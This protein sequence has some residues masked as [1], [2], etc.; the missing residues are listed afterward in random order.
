MKKLK[1]AV[2]GTGALGGFYGGML[3]K[4]G[5][6]VHFMFHNDF[7][8][9]KENGLK[10][11]SVTGDFHLMN[12]NAYNNSESMPQCDIVLVCLKTTNN[13]QLKKILPPLLHSSTCV[14]LIQNGLNIEKELA[15]S[16]TGIDI[17]GG[18]AFI[19]SNKVGKGHIVHLDYGKLTLGSYNMKNTDL[20]KKVCDDFISAGVPA[21]LSDN[22]EESRWRKLVWNIPYNGLCVVLNATTGELMSNPA[23]YSLIRDIM[24]E[25]VFA[26]R[27][28]NL[29]IDES[30]VQEMLEATS[31]MKTY[32]PSMKLDFDNKRQLETDAIYSSPVKEAQNHGFL[33]SKVK[34]LEQQLIFIQDC[35]LN[36]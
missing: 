36:E 8:Y 20:L 5:E 9:V 21:E 14:I 11:D 35:Y 16:F 31:V 10:V 23:S 13:W 24:S 18:L 32:A 4:A 33:M 3:A 2:V 1:Y 12:I 19:C 6:E 22:L 15:T 17:A 27:A 29:N 30:F 34:M 26:A 25:V 28:C 7:E